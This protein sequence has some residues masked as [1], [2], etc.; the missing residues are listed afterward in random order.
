MRSRW[1]E[2]ELKHLCRC[3]TYKEET[4]ISYLTALFIKINMYCWVTSLL[5]DGIVLLFPRTPIKIFFTFRKKKKEYF[6]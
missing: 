1:R 2:R 6:S 3:L 5:N 4:N